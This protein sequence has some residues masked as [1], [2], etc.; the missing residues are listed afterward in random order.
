MV[1]TGAP[2]VQFSPGSRIRRSVQWARSGSPDGLANE[3][4]I[5]YVRKIL[6]ICA[7]RLTADI[8]L[9][10][11]LT[12]HHLNLRVDRFLESVC[13]QNCRALEERTEV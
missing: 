3:I 11:D 13:H 4:F 2:K 5:I 9:F 6:A 8:V 10:L 7:E 12:T 1:Y